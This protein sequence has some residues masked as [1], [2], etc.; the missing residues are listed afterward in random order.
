[1]SAPTN[2]HVDPDDWKAGL[3]GLVNPNVPMTASKK[4]FL[5]QNDVQSTQALQ[6]DQPDRGSE[7][8]S[9]HGADW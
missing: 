4:R 1:M 6:S 9:P 5:A 7:A 3:F 2:R 8:D